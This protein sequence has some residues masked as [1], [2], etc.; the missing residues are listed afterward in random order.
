MKTPRANWRT[1]RRTLQAL[2]PPASARGAEV[3]WRDFHTRRAFHPQHPVYVPP[4]ILRIFLLP[5][6]AAASV[7]VFLI[8]GMLL[9]RGWWTHI[10]VA[11]PAGPYVSMTSVPDVTTQATGFGVTDVESDDEDA[12]S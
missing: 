7:A 12:E 5:A 8:G 6:L 2:P 4:S 10:P 11:P 9:A 3:F 1:V